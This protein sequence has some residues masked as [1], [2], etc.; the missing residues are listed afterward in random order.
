MQRT[1]TTPTP[2]QRPSAAARASWTQEDTESGLWRSGAATGR[3]RSAEGHLQAVALRLGS[4]RRGLWEQRLGRSYASVVSDPGAAAD[5]LS[6]GPVGCLPGADTASATISRS[7]GRSTVRKSLLSACRQERSMPR[8]CRFHLGIII[9]VALERA[10]SSLK[11]NRRLS[12]NPASSWPISPNSCW[13]CRRDASSVCRYLPF[14]EDRALPSGVLG[15]VEC[16]H[17]RCFRAVC[18][19]FSRPAL[20]SPFRFA[21]LRLPAAARRGLGTAF[22]PLGIVVS[23]RSLS[24]RWSWPSSFR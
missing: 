13:T 14:C 18:R 21:R 22:G 7:D 2:A 9:A 10:Y 5:W 16:S 11:T 17:G 15:P 20:V 19:S 23:L 3:A 6:V 4:G 1:P 12:A 24:V 8:P